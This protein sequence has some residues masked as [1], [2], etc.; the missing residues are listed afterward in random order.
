MFSKKYL[1]LFLILILGFSNVYSQRRSIVSDVRFHKLKSDVFGNTR[2][3]RVLVPPRYS[4]NKNRRY[5]ILY[6]NDGQNLFQVRTAQ[7]KY[8]EW[9]IDETYLDMMDSREIEP[10]IIVG[11]DNAGK[12]GRANEYLP[13]EDGLL[14][15]T[16]PEPQ[17]AKYPKF[18]TEEVM[19]FIESKYRIKKGAEFTGLGGASYGSL[20]SLYTAI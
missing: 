8:S 9:G 12:T 2:T 6:L 16:I 7:T 11:I 18:L 19:P 20:I 4:R 3:I 1:L 10:I 5:S 13:Y 14:T 17:G 15:P